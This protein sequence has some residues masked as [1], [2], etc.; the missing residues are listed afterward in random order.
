MF[1]CYNALKNTPTDSFYIPYVLV[2]DEVYYLN[3]V[4][5]CLR[6]S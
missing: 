6:L 2:Q 4:L 1:A 5:K 3:L